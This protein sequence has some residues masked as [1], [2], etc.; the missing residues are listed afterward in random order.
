MGIYLQIPI[1][2]FKVI[3]Y[4]KMVEKTYMENT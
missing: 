2:C 1:A 4:Q 3:I